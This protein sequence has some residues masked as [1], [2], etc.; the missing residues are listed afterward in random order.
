MFQRSASFF[1]ALMFAAPATAKV[2]GV[3][4]EASDIAERLGR[5]KTVIDRLTEPMDTGGITRDE[6]DPFKIAWRNWGNARAFGNWS[7]RFS[8]WNG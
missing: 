8:Q 3:L 1:A 6:T 4:P 7:E 5:A 2:G